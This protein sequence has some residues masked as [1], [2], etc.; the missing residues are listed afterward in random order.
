M[1]MWYPNLLD[2][3]E[4]DHSCSP[5]MLSIDNSKVPNVRKHRSA[6]LTHVPLSGDLEHSVTLSSSPEQVR[7]MTEVL[8]DIRSSDDT[9][10]ATAPTH[11]YIYPITHDSRSVSVL[12]TK[13][14]FV[15][16]HLHDFHVVYVCA[17]A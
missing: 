4:R 1:E 14:G 7:D 8:Y 15:P 5:I 13:T 9:V 16:F 3:W 17:C 2:E 11:M 6:A 12:I 10:N